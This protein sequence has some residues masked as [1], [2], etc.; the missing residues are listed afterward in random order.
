[1][2]LLQF[3]MMPF[4]FHVKHFVTLLLKCAT[5]TTHLALMWLFI[6]YYFHILYLIKLELICFFL[7][8]TF[9]FASLAWTHPVFYCC[10][11]ERTSLRR[12]GQ[13]GRGTPLT[14][15]RCGQ[16]ARRGSCVYT[17]PLPRTRRLFWWVEESSLKS[18]VA[19][20][21][22]N[23]ASDRFRWQISVYTRPGDDERKL[24]TCGSGRKHVLAPRR[25]A[26]LLLAARSVLTGSARQDGSS[27]FKVFARVP[28]R[29]QP[30]TRRWLVC[31]N[32]LNKTFVLVVVDETSV[33]S[34]TVCFSF[35]RLW[36]LTKCKKRGDNYLLL[37]VYN[38]PSRHF[39]SLWLKWCVWLV[40]IRWLH[41]YHRCPSALNEWASSARAHG[42]SKFI[43]KRESHDDT[44]WNRDP[45]APVAS[46]TRPVHGVVYPE[47][48]SPDRSVERMNAM[49][50][51]EC[52]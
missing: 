29:S 20:N 41:T 52:V 33:F 51:C 32:T 5:Q 15:I 12:T 40:R 3:V 34:S 39:V 35:T 17:R 24:S 48:T 46:W 26:S 19:L 22:L 9:C 6:R 25:A 50:L 37:S 16:W 31:Y 13:W 1:M 21:A 42:I 38:V 36:S 30:Q 14:D 27:A 10:D 28:R 23:V 11:E 8:A 45:H 7:W 18:F 43:N 47:S 4:T 2:L 44:L 49:D